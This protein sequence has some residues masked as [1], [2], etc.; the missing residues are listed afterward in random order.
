MIK[1]IS[2]K[3]A[4]QKVRSLKKEQKVVVLV[5]GCF[6]IFHP[7]HILFLTEAKKKGDFLLVALESDQWIRQ[8][9]GKGR[10]IFSM[11]QRIELLSA[12]SMVDGILSL[13]NQADAH[14]LQEVAPSVLAVSD[15]DPYYS[16][17]KQATSRLGIEIAIVCPY[18]ARLSTSSLIQSCKRITP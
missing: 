1:A 15:K 5:T 18:D 6:D 13:K 14:L 12:L 10:P 4:A 11:K 16:Q 8:K 17:K 3:V 2:L 7:G 9:K